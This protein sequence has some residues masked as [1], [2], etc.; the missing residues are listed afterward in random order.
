MIRNLTYNEIRRKTMHADVEG[1]L[2]QLNTS[3][4]SFT[5]KGRRMTKQEVK[6]VLEYAV[7][8]GYKTTSELHDDDVEA[9]ICNLNQEGQP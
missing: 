6:A 7:M 3:W 4:S 2:M 9:I 8:K 1:A 5:H